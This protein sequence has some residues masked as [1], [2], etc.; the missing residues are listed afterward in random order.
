MTGPAASWHGRLYR[1]EL[2]HAPDSPF[3]GGQLESY[4]DG[5]LAVCGETIEMAG[6]WA[7]VRA[8]FPTAEV[9][10]ARGAILLPGFVD[11][12]VHFPQIGVLGAMGMPL[13]E[14]LERRTFPYEIRLRDREIARRTATRFV[15]QLA[16]NGTTSALVFGSHFPDAQEELF[17]AAAHIGLRIT[18]GL[19]VSDRNL[20]DDL[21]LSPEQALASGGSLMNRWH[22]RGRLRYAVTPRF[23]VSCSEAML[24]ACAELLTTRTDLWFTS[25]LNENLEEVAFVRDLFPNAR[26]YLDT[27]ERSGLVSARSVF[28]HNVHP[29][30]A[31]LS[32]LA[33]AGASIAHCPSSNSFLGS[34]LFAMRRH[35]AHGIRI[36]LGSD[37]GAGTGLGILKEACQAYQMQMIHPEREPLGPAHALY[38]ATRAGG[39]VLGLEQVGDLR[40]GKAADFVLIRPPVGSTLEAVLAEQDLPVQRLG[41]VITLAGEDSVWATYVGGS[42]IY[43]RKTFGG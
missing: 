2:Y 4:E 35:V 30:D 34:G 20:P 42:P 29:T 41:A 21:K 26:D 3:S 6:P 14:W 37:V 19:V 9:V 12:H 23:S 10:D 8:R 13:L 11:T 22:G 5:G 27:Y 1:A 24:D 15:S 7:S 38:L 17:A 36:A 18:S 39:D 33:T 31:E 40:P 16:R 25:H 28:A 32:R 43:D